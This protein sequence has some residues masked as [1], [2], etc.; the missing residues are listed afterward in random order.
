MIL[1]FFLLSVPLLAGTKCWL[2]PRA[3]A[4]KAPS[5]E[6]QARPGE[7]GGGESAA[8]PAPRGF[9]PVF[10]GLLNRSPSPPTAGAGEQTSGDTHGT[11]GSRSPAPSSS[12]GGAL[13]AGSGRG[14]PTTAP[15]R[16]R[17]PPPSGLPARR[18]CTLLWARSSGPEKPR[19]RI[20]CF[21]ESSPEQDGLW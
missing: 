11:T 7:T 12:E 3:A 8:S 6:Q 4:G 19:S 21:S 10:P 17:P 13:G 18:P 5:Q 1:V 9:S 2:G 15:P 20:K 16:P 14:P